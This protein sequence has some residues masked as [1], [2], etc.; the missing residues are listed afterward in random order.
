MYVRLHISIFRHILFCNDV[1]AYSKFHT[2]FS[3]QLTSVGAKTPRLDVATTADHGGTLTIS[4]HVEQDFSLI[5]SIEIGKSALAFQARTILASIGSNNQIVNHGT[6]NNVG[7][8]GH[9]D[10]S[11]F[12]TAFLRLRIHHVDCSQKGSYYCS[13]N[14]GVQIVEKSV[15]ICGMFV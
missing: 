5:Q 2:I 9:L 7:V 4:C 3:N 15:T 12:A 14:G 6:G 11:A 10:S 1:T 8:E 13:V